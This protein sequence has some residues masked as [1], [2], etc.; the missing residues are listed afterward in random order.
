MNSSTLVQPVTKQRNSSVEI[1]RFTFMFLIVL[2]HVY[3]HGSGLDYEKIYH[4]GACSYNMSHLLIFSLGKIGVTG[5]MFISGYYGI[6]TSRHKIFDMILILLFY[7]ILLT[8]IGN[9]NKLL[10][11]LHPFDGWWFISAYLFIMFLAPLIESCLLFDWSVVAF[12]F[13]RTKYLR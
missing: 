2:L 1:L 11:F 9:G 4:W 10:L 12:T 8:P 7:L 3:A 13:A 5:F 6:R